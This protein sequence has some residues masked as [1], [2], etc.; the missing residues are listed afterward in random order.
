MVTTHQKA[1]RLLSRQVRSVESHFG[2]Q[3]RRKSEREE[4][5]EG[6]RRASKRRRVAPE[7][8]ERKRKTE[9]VKRISEWA[10]RRTQPGIKLA[11]ELRRAQ[12]RSGAG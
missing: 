1:K 9:L 3:P 11:E 7:Q 2:T 4:E 5:R 12:R 6:V 10:N 8:L